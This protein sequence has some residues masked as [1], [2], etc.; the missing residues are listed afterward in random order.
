[1]VVGT[2]IIVGMYSPT[3]P[4]EELNELMSVNTHDYFLEPTGELRRPI[5]EV[6]EEIEITQAIVVIEEVEPVALIEPVPEPKPARN[7]CDPDA[8]F[9]SWMDY[10]S[11]TNTNSLQ[12]SLQA[13]AET[14]GEGLR[15]VNGLTLIAINTRYGAVGDVLTLTFEDGSMER[16]MIGDLKAHTD[17]CSQPAGNGRNSI[18]EII[19]DSNLINKG[20]GEIIRYS[21]KISNIS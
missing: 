21:K 16:V 10:R 14:T 19:V 1:M 13:T 8:D 9:A 2:L 5:M 4:L 15:Q 20:P 7:V 18:I 17:G 11:I 6:F 3:E 12:Y